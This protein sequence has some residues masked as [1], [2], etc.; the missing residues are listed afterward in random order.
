LTPLNKEQTSCA[1]VMGWV[2]GTHYAIF[3]TKVAQFSCDLATILR[4]AI[5][6]GATLHI[7]ATRRSGNYELFPIPTILAI[8]RPGANAS[9]TPENHRRLSAMPAKR[10]K[11]LRLYDGS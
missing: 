3:M 10:A 2:R 8:W 1:A 11:F 5:F 9:A 6:L 4:F 7:I